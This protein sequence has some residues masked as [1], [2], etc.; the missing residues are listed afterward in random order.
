M[1]FKFQFSLLYLT[2]GEGQTLTSSYDYVA[3]VP[4]TFV[5]ECMHF[6]TPVRAGILALCVSSNLRHASA[7]LSFLRFALLY[8]YIYARN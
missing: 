8:I 2:V 1:Q 3:V 4:D 5:T 7:L 6:P